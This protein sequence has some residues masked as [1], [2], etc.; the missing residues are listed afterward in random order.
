MKII[1][2]A[3]VGAL[4]Y[5]KVF[6]NEVIE[7]G[8][9]HNARLC[10]IVD[11]SLKAK[12]QYDNIIER[13]VKYYSNLDDMYKEID[14]DL[15][16]IASPIQFHCT[17]ACKAMENGS[18]VL[19]EKPIA[20]CT[21]DAKEIIK[22][23][24]KTGK[25][26]LLGYQLFY[27]ETIRKVKEIILSDRLGKLKL[28]KCIVLWPRSAKYYTRN[29]WAGKILDENGR[30]VYDSVANN[31][32][33]HFFMN[34]L[35][36]AG[37]DMESS[38]KIEKINAKLSRANPIET[39][40]TCSMQAYT[41]DGTEI[42]MFASHATEE[43]LGAKYKLIFDRGYI[44]CV[45]DTWRLHQGENTQIIGTSYHNSN[46]KIWDMVRYIR[47][48]GYPIKCTLENGLEHAG[49]IETLGEIP[50]S[51]ITNN[52]FVNSRN[53]TYVEGLGEKLN[54]AYEDNLLPEVL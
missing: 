25:K 24:N 35:Y 11:V 54:K 41:D 38:G 28:I 34:V 26:I 22:A 37:K 40:D 53:Y 20:G 46:K 47:D 23:R 5:G 4:G 7:N 27:D 31:A 15:V 51:E 14:V 12:E 43:L 29:K 33:A 18:H 19:L 48:D 30:A 2:I 32:M 8:C 36:L 52:V 1:D 3:V 17:H 13:G 49:M 45:D 9:R 44:D 10:A 6:I 16:L 50:V 21:G 39:Y 42:L